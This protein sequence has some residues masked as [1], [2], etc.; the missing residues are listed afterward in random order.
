LPEHKII[1][2]PLPQMRPIDHLAC[3][4]CG[5]TTEI[6]CDCGE[7][8]VYVPA[9]KL[10]EKAIME[11]PEK[12]DRAIAAEIGVSHTSV[13]NARKSVGKDLPPEKRTGKDGKQYKANGKKTGGARIAIPAGYACLS[14]AMQYGLDLQ[15]SGVTSENVARRLGIAITSYTVGRDIVLLSQR[16]DLSD[17]DARI[18]QK[19]LATLNEERRT[20]FCR[21][22]IEPIVARVWGAK[23][24]RLKSDKRRLDDFRSAISYV[25][26]TCV[27]AADMTIPY[28]G[29]DDCESTTNELREAEQ[30]LNLLRRRINGSK[31]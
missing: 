15:K 13:S 1:Q 28:L 16:A 2:F 26:T 17:R 9:G 30:S 21:A 5:A 25:L 8:Y 18:V 6:K 4:Q 27:T 3:R 14:D 10:A 29:N 19:A 11:N 20:E 23:G 7:A 22:L 12:S 24:H 31:T